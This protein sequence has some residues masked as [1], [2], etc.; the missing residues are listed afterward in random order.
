MSRQPGVENIEDSATYAS[1]IGPAI[2]G[3]V[4]LGNVV[5]WLAARPAGEPTGRFIGELCAAEAV[6]LFSS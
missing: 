4:A 3:A 5:I 1:W 2:L 6:L